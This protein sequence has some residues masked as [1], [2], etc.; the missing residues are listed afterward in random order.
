[1]RR[2]TMMTCEIDMKLREHFGIKKSRFEKMKG[3]FSTKSGFGKLKE[4]IRDI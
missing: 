1:M 4:R 2:T 3:H